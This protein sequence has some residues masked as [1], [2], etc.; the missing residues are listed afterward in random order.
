MKN[1]DKFEPK[2]QDTKFTSTLNFS[3]QNLTLAGIK[4]KAYQI[5]AVFQGN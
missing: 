4:I 1:I 5:L 3:N 2:P